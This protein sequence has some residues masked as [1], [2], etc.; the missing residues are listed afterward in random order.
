MKLTLSK[1]KIEHDSH[2]Y[3]L[4]AFLP[5]DNDKSKTGFTQK[6]TFHATLN[7]VAAKMLRYELNDV[8]AQSVSEISAEIEN[9]V[10]RIEKMLEK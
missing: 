6:Q 10:G 9:A 1:F 7:Q 5:T 8:E 3:A 4:T 2:A